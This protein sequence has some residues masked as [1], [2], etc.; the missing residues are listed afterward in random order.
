MGSAYPTIL[1]ITMEETDMSDKLAKLAVAGIPVSQLQEMVSGLDALSK[2]RSV[3]QGSVCGCGCDGSGGTLCG[4]GCSNVSRATVGVLDP[5][6]QAGITRAELD[7]VR[8]QVGQFKDTLRAQ[9]RLAG[10][11][12]R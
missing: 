3:E 8:A 6:N 11:T 1:R 2:A 10:I 5:A 4:V 7:A 9:A 12:L